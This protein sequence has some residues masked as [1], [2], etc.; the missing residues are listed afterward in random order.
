MDVL[1]NYVAPKV[2]IQMRIKN[3]IGLYGEKQYESIINESEVLVAR[4]RTSMSSS[5]KL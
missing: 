2:G 4:F 5:L 1:I 3:I